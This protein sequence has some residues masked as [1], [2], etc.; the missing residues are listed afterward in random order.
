MD[1]KTCEILDKEW[2]AL[3]VEAKKLGFTIEEIKEY[4]NK[5]VKT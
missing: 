1:T 3:M 5:T 2:T 4:L